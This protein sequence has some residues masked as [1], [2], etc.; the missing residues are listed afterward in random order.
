MGL[1]IFLAKLLGIYFLIVAVLW[2]VRKDQLDASFKDVVS[3]K[4]LI[5]FSGLMNI[6]FGL[7]IAIA[8]PILQFSWIGL[9][10]ILAYLM[11][12]RGIIRVIYPEHEQEMMG[13]LMNKGYWP[14]IA[15][16]ILIGLFL[17]ISGFMA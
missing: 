1:S 10:T 4:G 7:A 5:V 16:L 12:I 15:V 6:L 13:K 11:I 9:I 3:S 17:T 2:V 8:H 14:T